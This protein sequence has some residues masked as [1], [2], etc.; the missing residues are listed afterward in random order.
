M[1]ND[2]RL[3]GS[4]PSDS[5]A[6]FQ[7]DTKEVGVGWGTGLLGFLEKVHKAEK[8]LCFLLGCRCTRLTPISICLL[9]YGETG[10]GGKHNALKTDKEEKEGEALVL[11]YFFPL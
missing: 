8:F 5:E 4:T 9:V 6:V 3:C 10:P 7:L 2:P 11:S 1:L